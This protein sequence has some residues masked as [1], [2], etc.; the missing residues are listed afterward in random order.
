MVDVMMGRG[1]AWKAWLNIGVDIEF[2]RDPCTTGI[3]TEIQ[4]WFE[5]NHIRISYVEE[6]VSFILL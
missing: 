1:G 6:N 5:A 2:F 4:L 3:Y